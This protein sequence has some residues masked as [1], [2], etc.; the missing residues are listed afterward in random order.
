[1]DGIGAMFSSSE[2]HW[3]SMECL[4]LRRIQCI[5]SVSLELLTLYCVLILLSGYAG[6]YGLSLIVGSYPVL[7][8]SLAAHA[9]QFA[10]LVFFENPRM[11]GFT[12]LT[13]RHFTH[14][15]SADIERTYGQRKP[16]AARVPINPSEVRRAPTR[17][18][19]PTS[20]P[21]M[22]TPV[23]QRSESSAST[24][25]STPAVTEGDTATSTD[26]ETETEHEHEHDH[27][28]DVEADNEAESHY[29]Q[30][31]QTV[32]ERLKAS[33]AGV[34]V[35]GV[36]S[37]DMTRVNSPQGSGAQSP[38]T[39]Q[40]TKYRLVSQHDLLNRYFRKDLTLLHNFDPLR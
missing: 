15:L 17:R 22:S 34:A 13:G 29:R 7:F 9:A 36:D 1:M 14:T 32:N 26:L 11:L 28:A 20:T 23:H 24:D 40:R 38:A 4:S 30:R 31:Y 6:Y 3:C 37:R 12:F 27:D 33:V 10:F 35:G 25:I 21:G 16:L 19:S 8:A 5:Q 18:T 39:V 2:E